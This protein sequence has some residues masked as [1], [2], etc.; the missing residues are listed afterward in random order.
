MSRESNCPIIDCITKTLLISKKLRKTIINDFYN[1]IADDNYNS[2]T[3]CTLF[4]FVNL[5][6]DF[7]KKESVNKLYSNITSNNGLS[8]CHR[9]FNDDLEVWRSYRDEDYISNLNYYELIDKFNLIHDSLR[10]LRC[11][12]NVYGDNFNID[13]KNE[14]QYH[15]DLTTVY[16]SKAFIE[17]RELLKQQRLDELFVIEDE[18]FEL[19]NDNIEIAKTERQLC[20]IGNE[21]CICVGGYGNDVRE[22]D[23]RIAYI[24]DENKYK[25]CLE[26]KSIKDNKKKDSYKYELRQAKL[27]RNRLVGTN[28]KYYK[29]VSDWCE[30]NDIAIVTGDM[31]K[32]FEQED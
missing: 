3:I 14:K 13:F 17:A 30:E 5:A 19:S 28:E 4:N 11:I 12:Q 20:D 31:N 25:V 7:K 16:T 21:M 26:L 23:T 22:R 9:F 32:R 27:T 8:S 10:L 1:T 6:K 2:S 24:K 18:C 15:D 29:I